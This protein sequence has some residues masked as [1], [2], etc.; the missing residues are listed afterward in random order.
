MD[1]RDYVD[2][3]LQNSATLNPKAQTQGA[4]HDDYISNLVKSLLSKAPQSAYDL[5]TGKT[6]GDAVSN[7]FIY[8]PQTQRPLP[9]SP[10]YALDDASKIQDPKLREQAINDASMNMVMGMTTPLEPKPSANLDDVMKDLSKQLP[11]E[12]T[13]DPYQY[14]KKRLP[15]IE[16]IKNGVIKTKDGNKIELQMDDGGNISW[17]EAQK[18]GTGQGTRIVNALKEWAMEN[19]QYLSPEKDYNSK[20]WKK[21][22][23]SSTQADDF[24]TRYAPWDSIDDFKKSSQSLNKP[25]LPKELEGLAGE[26]KKKF[27]V[28]SS[29]DLEAG[30]IKGYISPK[31]EVIPVKDHSQIAPLV[32]R[33]GPIGL[34]ANEEV[35]KQFMN[36][37][38]AV[39]MYRN[40]DEVGIQF[41]KPI[42]DSQLET[43]KKTLIPDG[44]DF[45]WDGPNKTSGQ[46]HYSDVKDG[47]K[48]IKGL[49]EERAKA[50]DLIN[51]REDE[52]FRKE[53]TDIYN[54]AKGVSNKGGAK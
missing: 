41:E 34:G 47:W 20:F 32:G 2:S 4:K 18:K 33:N 15:E 35:N 21:M 7:N 13:K 44:G 27:G 9:A 11:K 40:A 51:G 48:K 23:F 49:M 46:F 16:E 31:G 28:L 17:L 39:R 43:I 52:V 24:S 29:K 12:V 3:V 42:S 5:L 10:L 6:I 54:Q 8:N 36:S 38:G 50:N 53:L 37:S 25:S 19:K 1:I 45:Y 30:G 14:L 26:A 22:G